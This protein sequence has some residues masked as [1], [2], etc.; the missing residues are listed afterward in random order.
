MDPNSNPPVRL[1][2]SSLHSLLRKKVVKS[3]ESSIEQ[4]LN[5]YDLDVNGIVSWLHGE[6]GSEALLPR[7][8]DEE[9]DVLPESCIGINR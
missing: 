5:D 7:K 2:G 8:K 6:A 9:S 4:L 1:S 3:Q